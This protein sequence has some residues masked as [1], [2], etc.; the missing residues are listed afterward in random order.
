MTETLT[1]AAVKLPHL[2]HFGK[3]PRQILALH[4]SLAHGGVW[5]PMAEELGLAEV[6]LTAPDMPGHGRS[7][8]WRPGSMHDLARDWA[9]DL[10]EKIGG[11]APVDL[12]GHSFGGTVA[13]RVTLERPDLVRSLTLFEPVLFAV[14]LA[15]GSAEAQDWAAKEQAFEA[16]LA[17]GDREGAAEWFQTLWGTG[18]P[19][20]RMPASQRAYIV[21]RIDAIPAAADV[22]RDDRV[23]MLQP[24]RLQSIPVPVLLAEGGNSPAV[25]RAISEGLS[26][27]IPQA[28]R[29]VQEGAGHM[30][31][32]THAGQ[33]AAQ[34]RAHLGL[35]G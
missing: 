22:V 27:R 7:P 33:M 31:P 35:E 17:A 19:L 10:L 20:S 12:F 30:L 16:R 6:S 13:L 3:G 1:S 14:A 9:V 5:Q 32:I 24:G 29:L 2:R 26:R 11:G 15:D 34:I 23:G 18:V 21:D 25:I 4:C 28:Q 8:H